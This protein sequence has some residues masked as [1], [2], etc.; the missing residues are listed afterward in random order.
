MKLASITS[1]TVEIVMLFSRVK[2]IV[3]LMFL[4]LDLL[5]W[6]MVIIFSLRLIVVC[7]VLVIVVLEGVLNCWVMIRSYESTIGK[8]DL[9]SVLTMWVFLVMIW[10]LYIVVW[11]LCWVM[12]E[13]YSC[14]VFELFVVYFIVDLF[15]IRDSVWRA[16]VSINCFVLESVI[17]YD[18]DIFFWKIFMNV[19]C[20]VFS[21]LLL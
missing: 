21:E 1:T 20:V 6:W 13:K 17:K 4:M 14:F 7:I 12:S 18:D 10:F 8:F 9:T 16:F 19:E 11:F 15:D 2:F 3:V 5:V